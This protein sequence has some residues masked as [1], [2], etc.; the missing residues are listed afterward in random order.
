LL[1]NLYLDGLDKA[2]NRGRVI[3]AVMVRYA[4]DFVVLCPKGQGA[5]MHRRLKVWLEKRKLK[6]NEVKT[7]VVDFTQE[8][9]EFLGFQLSWRKGRSGRNYSH[10]EPSAKST[11]AVRNAVREETG[12]DTF[13]KEPA[14]VIQRINQRV[15]GWSGYF[16][17]GNSTKVFATIQWYVEMRVGGW[18]WKKH[19][20]RKGKY[21]ATYGRGTLKER[22]GLFQMPTNAAWRKS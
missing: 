10:C 11:Q 12:R 20:R 14:E 5:E 3:K 19:G 4:D 16:H 22:Y 17:H 9:L 7:K 15:R 13:W 8:G 18:L 2:V 21:D 1:A 6:L